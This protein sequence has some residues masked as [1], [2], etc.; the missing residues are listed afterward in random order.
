MISTPVL[1]CEQALYLGDI[2]K[3]G[4]ARGTRKRHAR[5]YARRVLARLASLSQI[6]ELAGKYR[7][8]YRLFFL[9]QQ[10]SFVFITGCTFKNNFSFCQ[11]WIF[12]KIPFFLLATA[13]ES[14]TTGVPTCPKITIEQCSN[15]PTHLKKTTQVFLF[16]SPSFDGLLFYFIS[17]L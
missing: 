14:L 1:A 11:V 9:S 8:C 15:I 6:R 13:V 5:G 2:V 10:F 12:N 3:R 4:R 17:F 16:R 7:S